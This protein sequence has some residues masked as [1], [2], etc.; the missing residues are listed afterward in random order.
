MQ[1]GTSVD[2]SH[3]RSAHER[4]IQ[5]QAQGA[6][7]EPEARPEAIVIADRGEFIDA[8]A[9]LRRGQ[10][11]VHSADDDDAR[12]VIEGQW[13]WTSWRPLSLYGLLSELPHDARNGRLRCYRLSPRGR[14]FA[15]RACRA[16]RQRPL[17]QRLLVRFTG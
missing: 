16:W 15:D 8:L 1:L 4:Q 3:E 9:R 17:W 14:D 2:D 5:G 11:L 13:M 10:V 12:C 7:R 6:P